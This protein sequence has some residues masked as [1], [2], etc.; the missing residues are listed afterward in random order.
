MYDKRGLMEIRE[1]KERMHSERLYYCNEK[2]LVQE[3][4]MHLELLHKYHQLP[5]SAQSE[6][7][8]LL[9]EMLASIGENCSIES[10]FYA[11]WGG[12]HLHLGND[13]YINF[14]LTLVDD[15]DIY[16]DDHVMIGP[17]VT[18]ITGT[19]PIH[20]DLRRKQA[21]YNKAV[22]IHQ[23]VWIGSGTTILPGVSIGENSIIGAGSFVTKDIPANV[24]AFGQPCKVHRAITKED[25][26]YYD[27]HKK[28]DI[29]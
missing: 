14:N 3:Q 5:P 10:P 8:A 29:K 24:I 1:I 4:L 27:T 7:H 11:N 25:L 17:N 26:L 2:E 12:K 18:I 6:K 13:V 16:I 22:H 19:H 9:K 15:T 21:Q 20:P 28:T 23:N